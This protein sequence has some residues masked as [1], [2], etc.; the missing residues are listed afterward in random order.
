MSLTTS[1]PDSGASCKPR[2]RLLNRSTFAMFAGRQRSLILAVAGLIAVGAV[3]ILTTRLQQQG[4]R[5][6]LSTFDV[7]RFERNGAWTVSRCSILGEP[8]CTR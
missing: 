2:W 7:S 6:D 4:E 1:R 5:L 8:G 3:V